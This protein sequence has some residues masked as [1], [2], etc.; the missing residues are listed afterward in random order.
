MKKHLAIMSSKMAEAVLL[1]KKTVESRFSLSKI[2]PFGQIS[3]GDLVYIK[4]PGGEIVGQFRVE[5]AIFFDGLEPK[6]I[7][8]IKDEYQSRLSSSDSEEDRRYWKDKKKSH[9]ASLIFISNSERFITS[10]LKI[11]K[12]DQRGW[13]VLG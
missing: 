4:L 11:K 7:D 2:P 3:K 8:K 9:Y 10:P 12:K 13:M 1:G 5:K 6:D